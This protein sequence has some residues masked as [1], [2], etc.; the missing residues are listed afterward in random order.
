MGIGTRGRS[1]RWGESMGAKLPDG[2]VISEDVSLEELREFLAADQ[3]TVHADPEFKEALRKK[4]W[5]MLQSQAGRD[6]H[7]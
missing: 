5:D 6:R 4:L 2:V 1:Y 3:L 7:E